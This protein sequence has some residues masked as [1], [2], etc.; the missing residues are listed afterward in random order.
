MVHVASRM[1]RRTAGLVTGAMVSAVIGSPRLVHVRLAISVVMV[2]SLLAGCS[3]PP[4]LPTP[5]PDRVIRRDVG[6]GWEI[7]TVYS[8][9]EQGGV[10]TLASECPR[11]SKAVGGG[12]DNCSG[13]ASFDILDEGRSWGGN[14]IEKNHGIYA[15]GL[16]P[17]EF[18]SGRSFD[19]PRVHDGP[20][21]LLPNT[22]YYEGMK[23]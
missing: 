19:P 10:V 20:P 21:P 23:H 5:E 13:N 8:D 2:A 22:K 17:L 16:G 3:S 4:E 6:D 12:A 15:R 7:V 11:G 1:H 18:A 14:Q 9:F